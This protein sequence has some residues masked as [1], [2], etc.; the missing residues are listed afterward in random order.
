MKVIEVKVYD[1]EELTDAA[2]ENAR[3]WWRRSVEFDPDF[4]DINA[5]AEIFGISE[6][7]IAYS[8]FGSQGDGASFT[9]KYDFRPNSCDDIFRYA[10]NDGELQ[11]IARALELAQSLCDNKL[12]ADII[13]CG[14]RYY[15]E[16]TVIFN[17]FRRDDDS[18]PDNVE[19]LIKESMR[20][21]MKWIY[22]NIESQYDYIMSDKQVDEDLTENCYYFYKNGAIFS[23]ESE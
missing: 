12:Q 20:S 10:P 11:E 21:F 5:I 16:N 8:G 18:V 4:E 6:M 23:H 2:K 15:H 3:S 17:I 14:H 22:N 9:G 7:K 1:F 19:D 13:R